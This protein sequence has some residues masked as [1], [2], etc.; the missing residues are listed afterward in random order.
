MT[1]ERPNIL[2]IHSDQHRYDCLGQAG[3]P[4]AHTPHL[5]RL[6]DEGVTFSH[7]FTPIPTC[8]PARQSLLSGLWPERHGGLWNYDITLP[9][10]HFDAPTWTEA[11]H[12]SGYAL[13]YVGKWHVHPTRTPL[14]FGFDDYV[15]TQD[16]AT[17]RAGQG[18]PA[19]EPLDAGALGLDTLTSR[20]FGGRD[21]APVEQSR[22]HWHADQ[23]I[24]LMHEYARQGQPW[25]IRLDFEEPHLPCYPAERFAD[26]VDPDVIP[27][28]GSFA[29]TFRHKPYI[30]HQQLLT[31][32]IQDLTWD[33][34]GQ[35]VA[36]YLGMVAQMDDAIGR[37]LGALDAEGLADSTLLIYT[38]DHGDAC[39]SH[40]MIDKHYI[41]YEGVVRVP[42]IVRWPG[43]TEAG[44]Q[45]DA[46]ASHALDLASTMCEAGGIAGPAAMQGRSLVPWLRG[47]TV[48]D[49]RQHVTST[50]NGAQFGLYNMRMLRDRRWKYVWNPTDLDELYDLESDPWEL[51]NRI[52]EPALQPR[53]QVMRHTL[54]EALTEQDDDLVSRPWLR[55]QLATGHKLAR[56]SL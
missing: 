52:A 49:W 17:W 47:D 36:H 41:M 24:N 6:A 1:P 13:G 35:Y 14:D 27:P 25:H 40:R 33:V 28:W 2:L 37:V 8:C 54:L 16:Y 11:L 12:A 3:N 31:W 20:W 56:R 29:E 44:S 45:C 55:E 22:T 30:Q 51:K 38:T 5:D 50:F 18:L 32:G 21:P 7:A 34:W 42:L 10:S 53:V 9:V 4:L 26:L 43:V 46:F 19:Y 48:A 15:S 39:G 23:A